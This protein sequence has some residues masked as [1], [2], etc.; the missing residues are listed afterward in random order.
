[1]NN[2]YFYQYIIVFLNFVLK[3]RIIRPNFII[4]ALI[5]LGM[6]KIVD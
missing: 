5:T 1:M 3:N 6:C 4:I 2:N